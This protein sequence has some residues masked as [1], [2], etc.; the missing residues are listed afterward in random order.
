[1]FTKFKGAIF[2]LDGTLVDSMG[3]WYEIDVEYLARF[4]LEVPDDLQKAIEGFSFTETA[5]Y[6]KN[7]FE[8]EDDIEA[9]K[10]EWNQ[11]AHTHYEKKIQIKENVRE[12]LDYLKLKGYK[13]AI[14]TS[15]SRHLA[16]LALESNGIDKYFEYLVTSCDVEKGKPNPDVY[17]RASRLLDID[18]AELIAFEDTVAGVKAAKGA[19]IYTIGIYDEFS[20]NYEEEIRLLADRFIYDYEELL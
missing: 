8:L 11:M 13:M 7:R 19:N 17:L 6:F 18:V 3:M 10:N 20:K 5:T 14:A 15:N 4:N 2:D 9:I 1:M 16:Q 12:L